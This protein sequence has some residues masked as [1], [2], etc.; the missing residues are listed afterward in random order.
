[1][2]QDKDW[3]EFRNCIRLTREIFAQDAFKPF[4]KHEIQPGAD[5]QSDDDLD[6]FIREHAESAYHPC[7]TCR[8]GRAD[9]PQAVVDP[10]GRVIGVEGLRV[11][12]SSIFPRITNGN[13]NAP[14]IM[15]GEK[16]SDHV[17]GLDPLA[18]SNDA[19]WIHPDWETS[20]R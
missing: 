8:M 7:G 16:I 17:L 9:D 2:S 10:Q 6:A 20:Q 12:D 5:L 1:M 15:V 14:S 19:P 13:L 18:A 3:E 11:A 4:V